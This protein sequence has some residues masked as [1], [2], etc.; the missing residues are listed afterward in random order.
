MNTF[1]H[2]VTVAGFLVIVWYL[3]LYLKSIFEYKDAR[4]AE[5][6]RRLQVEHKQEVALKQLLAQPMD[7]AEKFKI[8]SKFAEE[9]HERAVKYV[10]Q[11]MFEHNQ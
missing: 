8:V 3:R 5:I 1:L 2:L 11:D 4:R 9:R 10:I 7:D 6:K